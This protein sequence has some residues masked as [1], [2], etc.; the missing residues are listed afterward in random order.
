MS[1]LSVVHIFGKLVVSRTAVY[2]DTNQ[3]SFSLR[4]FLAISSASKIASD[5]SWD[6][7]VHLVTATVHE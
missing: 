4:K 2:N 7:A 1:G 5:C 6:A 3:I